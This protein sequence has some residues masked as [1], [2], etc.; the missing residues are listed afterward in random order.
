MPSH[1]K[2]A[3]NVRLNKEKHPEKYCHD[4]RCL[5]R[6]ET[7]QGFKPCPKHPAPKREGD[8][9]L[10]QF[11]QETQAPHSYASF[12]T[13][14]AARKRADSESRM[15]QIC[16]NTLFEFRPELAEE[17]RATE[18]DPFYDDSRLRAFYEFIMDKWN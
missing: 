7:R 14:T 1:S 2:V 15:G 5:W 16:F 3:M 18:K 17:I 11:R 8:I 10:A 9:T 6:T 12:C 13:L 4:S